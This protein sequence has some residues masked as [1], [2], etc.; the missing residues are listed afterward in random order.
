MV[1]NLAGQRDLPSLRSVASTVQAP[2]SGAFKPSA[3]INPASRPAVINRQG[4]A[5]SGHGSR[6]GWPTDLSDVEVPGAAGGSSPDRLSR[7][8][9]ILFVTGY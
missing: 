8:N 2:P 7:Q 9:W 3:V 6:H 1:G 4:R 5:P